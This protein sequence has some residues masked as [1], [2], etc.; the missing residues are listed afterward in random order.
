VNS[1]ERPGFFEQAAAAYLLPVLL[2]AVV[3]LFHLGSPPLTS[4]NEGLYAEVAREMNETGQFVIPQANGV[5][6]LEKPPLLYWLTALSMGL[7]G[8][9]A[10]A[11][12]LPS[13]LAAIVTVFVVV[14]AGRRLFGPRAGM[15]SG[16]T[17]AT[18]LGLA[19][20]ARQVLFDSLLTLW[21]TVA[22]LC[23]WFGT[24]TDEE[25]RL[26]R[27]TWLLAGYAALGLAVL[28]KGLVGLAIPA[29]IVLVYALFARDGDRLR[30]AVSAAG[31]LL[32]L[33][34]AVPWHLIAGWRQKQFF[35]FYFVNE[36]WLR[37]LGRREPA[38]F[39]ADPIFAPAAALLLLPLPWSAFLPAAIRSDLWGRRR[40][41]ESVFLICWIL[42]PVVFFT[43]SQTRTYYY[44]LPAVPPIALLLGRYW[45][46]LRDQERRARS[47]AL[48]WTVLLAGLVFWDLWLLAG[49]DL[50]SSL[51]EAVTAQIWLAGGLWLVAG[52]ATAL[53]L[54]L[55]RRPSAA[56]G[57]VGAGYVIAFIIA[58]R[59]VAAGGAGVLHSEKD[60]AKLV[61]IWAAP[62]TAVAVEG[63]FEN[64][65]SFGF[66][67]PRRFRPV[68]VV[69]ALG[70]GDLAFG[71]R[72]LS[73]TRTQFISTHP[74]IF[75]LAAS[76]PLYY[77]TIS[78]SRLD[79]PPWL[80]LVSCDDET[81]FWTNEGVP[82]PG[83]A[84][85]P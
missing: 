2:A 29:L 47:E 85:R 74:M 49:G 73:D 68:L 45:S 82:I 24:E 15:L 37:F 19:L 17:L 77:L 30:R 36:H 23:F 9:N 10:F 72:F 21:T 63:K 20:V 44:L 84:P 4:P 66:Y 18:S 50:G 58:A 33:A 7:S 27:K 32:L 61:Q 1:G 28:T 54:I 79:V 51:R 53:A 65:S 43:L 67:L 11:A 56:L 42:A 76:R 78:P 48:L 69:D 57:A 12:R 8:E 38:D 39:H 64:H 70:Q 62:G 3:F 34:V 31:L 26:A 14:G 6:Y 35:W 25:R 46:G 41:R 16:V 5:V 22:L 71:S 81:M 75:E 59:F 83:P 40:S 80:A 55:A 60:M 13:A 52:F